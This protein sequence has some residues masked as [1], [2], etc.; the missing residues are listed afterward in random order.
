MSTREEY[1]R[2]IQSLSAEAAKY[3]REKRYWKQYAAQ[4]EAR[5]AALQPPPHTDTMDGDATT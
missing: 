3:R 5:L 2:S 4:L 1:E